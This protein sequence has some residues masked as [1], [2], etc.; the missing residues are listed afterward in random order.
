[1]VELTVLLDLSRGCNIVEDSFPYGDGD[2][3][4]CG[5]HALRALQLRGV[6]VTGWESRGFYRGRGKSLAG[7]SRVDV[8]SIL[9]G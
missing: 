8:G 5:S 9:V 7:S 4:G 1:M 2:V 6:Y 3:V